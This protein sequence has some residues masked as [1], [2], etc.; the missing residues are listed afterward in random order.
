MNQSCLQISIIESAV[1]ET[2]KE[3]NLGINVSATGMVVLSDISA[4]T[5]IIL[6]DGGM[7]RHAMGCSCSY[8]NLWQHWR[9]YR[10]VM[11]MVS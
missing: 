11:P 6:S 8:A 4:T 9:K 7:N 1:V 10:Q 3:I 2:Q 5:V